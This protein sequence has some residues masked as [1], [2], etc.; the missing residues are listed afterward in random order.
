MEEKLVPKLR[1][2]ENC[3]YETKKVKTTYQ[4]VKFQVLMILTKD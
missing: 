2:N 3:S 4:K 1:F